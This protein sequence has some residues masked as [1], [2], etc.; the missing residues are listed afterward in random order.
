MNYSDDDQSLQVPWWAPLPTEHARVACLASG[1]LGSLKEESIVY[2][3]VD[4]QIASTLIA[5]LGQGVP[6]PRTAR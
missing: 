5:S 6:M 1:R 4:W 2:M 3:G